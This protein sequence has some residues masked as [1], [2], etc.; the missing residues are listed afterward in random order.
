MSSNEIIAVP[1]SNAETRPRRTAHLDEAH[2]GDIN[3]ALARSAIM[4]SR[5]GS[6]GAQGLRHYSP[7]SALASS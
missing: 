1:L 6:A 3:G 7:S 5:H 4:T 2:I